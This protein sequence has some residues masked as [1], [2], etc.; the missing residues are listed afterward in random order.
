M[1]AMAPRDW[2]RYARLIWLPEADRFLA[3]KV[4]MVTNQAPQ[5]K[6]SR[7]IIEESFTRVAVLMVPPG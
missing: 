6:N 4:P 1:A 5:M 7:N 2:V 3:R